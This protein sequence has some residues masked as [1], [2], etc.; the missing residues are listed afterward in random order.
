MAQ[1]STP[2]FVRR[3]VGLVGAVTC[4]A[5]V[6]MVSLS[7][8]AFA[9]AGGGGGHAGGGGH[10][11]GGHFG[12]GHAAFGHGGWG[13]RGGFERGG[14]HY[15]YGVDGVLVED[16]CYAPPVYAAPVY[17]AP[18]YVAPPVPVV[19]SPFGIFIR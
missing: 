17:G 4:L 14:H 3:T 2:S 12:G 11:G 10:V 19:V 13:G 5:A 1:N 6:G 18:V 16:C 9:H 8:S 15:H 7:G